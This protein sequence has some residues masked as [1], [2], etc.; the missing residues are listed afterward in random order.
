MLRV[1]RDPETQDFAFVLHPASDGC[2]R[3]YLKSAP[4]E[5]VSWYCRLRFLNRIDTLH[6]MGG[7]HQDG[8]DLHSGNI[9]I[10]KHSDVY[11]ADFGQ[12]KYV[13]CSGCSTCASGR[14]YGII[15]YICLNVNHIPR[16]L[17]FIHL[18]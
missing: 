3:D 8:Q 14:S 5:S 2:L 1:I 15:P 13:A 11:I 17:I 4:W 7:I 16:H 9:L 6:N 18:A 12:A 10:E